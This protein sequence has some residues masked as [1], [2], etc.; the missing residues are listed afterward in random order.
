MKNVVNSDL[1]S[2]IREKV[3][4]QGGTATRNKLRVR[5]RSCTSKVISGKSQ[6]DLI[7]SFSR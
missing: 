1:W 3:G 2:W 6:N 7:L 4:T 5:N